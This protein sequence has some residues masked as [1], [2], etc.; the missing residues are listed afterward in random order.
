MSSEVDLAEDILLTPAQFTAALAEHER[1]AA[2]LALAARRLEVAGEWSTDGSVSFAAW[3]RHHARMSARDAGRLIRCGRFL[4]RFPAI[5]DAAL[6]GVLSAGQVQAL[7]A[8]SSPRRDP[9]LAEHQRDLVG[10]LAKLSVAEAE[11]A[12]AVWRQRADALLDDDTPPTEPDR[13]LRLSRASDGALLG[14]F[15]YSDPHAAE[16]EHALR[17]ASTY[18]GDHDTRT[19]GQ[20]RADA[21]ADVC[22]FFNRNHDRPGTPR[23]HPHIELSLHA[24]TL[25]GNPAAVDADGRLVE[26]HTTNALLCDCIIHKIL[27]DAASVPTHYGRARYTVPRTLFRQVA[28]RDGGCRFPG[29]DR[30]VRWCDAHHIRHWRRHG[31]TDLPNLLLLCSRHHHLVHQLDLDLKLLPDGELHVTWPDGTHRI[32]HPRGAPPQQAP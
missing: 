26:A 3:L 14:A 30:P 2:V 11:Q 17:T 24:D 7:Q 22:E 10:T 31:T 19:V 28:A 1:R 5:A 25:G 29:C 4:D 9:L 21:L 15:T 18:D 12:C 6:S 8:V 20:R 32:S 23:N 27:R 13:N 16:I